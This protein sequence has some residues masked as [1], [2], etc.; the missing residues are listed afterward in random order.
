MNLVELRNLNLWFNDPYRFLDKALVEL[1]DT[2]YLKLPGMGKNLVT[3]NQE[4]IESIQANKYLIGGRG[5]KFLHHLVGP[6]VITLEGSNHTDIRRKLN[7]YFFQNIEQEKIRSISKASCFDYLELIKKNEIIS[8]TDWTNLVTLKTIINFL[9]DDLDIKERDELF[10]LITAWKASLKNSAYFFVKPLQINLSKNFGWGKYLDNRNKVHEKLKILINSKI[11]NNGLFSKMI[12]DFGWNDQQI[13]YETVS[14]LM[15]GHD[16]SAILI[17]WWVRNILTYH[18]WDKNIEIELLNSSLKESTRIT[19][20]VI[21]LTRVAN[22]LTSVGDYQ[23]NENEKVFP[24]I[25]LSHMNPNNFEQPKRFIIDR[26]TSKQFPNSTYFPFGFGDRLCLGKIFAEIQTLEI[27]KILLEE[28]N[29]QLVN[30]HV[31]AKRQFFLMVPE[32]G[33]LVK[34]I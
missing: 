33:T 24:C 8:I 18:Y 14:L 1:G 11:K 23:I 17:G 22:S 7:P 13:L 15:F 34:S 21:H 5:S 26:F 19:P 30:Q 10:Q 27:A 2:F 20:P 16:T 4:L 29:L 32:N 25:Y 28:K 31:P 3:G 6:S 9:F 12:H